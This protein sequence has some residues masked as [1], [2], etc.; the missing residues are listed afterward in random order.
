MVNL[1]EEHDAVVVDDDARGA[2]NTPRLRSHAMA[3]INLLVKDVIIPH[4]I[5]LT[6]PE[7][8]WRTLKNL[9]ESQGNARC[10]LL[11]SKL[12]ALRLEEGG[13]VFDMLKE[14]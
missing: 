6:K 11:K 5:E 4:I 8:L 9:F 7:E 1:N 14:I 13:S 3:L 10:L 12:H 2:R